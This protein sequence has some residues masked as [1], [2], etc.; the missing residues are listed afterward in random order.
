MMSGIKKLER[1]SL[2]YDRDK[3]EVTRRRFKKPEDTMIPVTVWS[4]GEQAKEI[5]F[6]PRPMLVL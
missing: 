6:C 3:S 4:S 5:Q 2:K 1:V